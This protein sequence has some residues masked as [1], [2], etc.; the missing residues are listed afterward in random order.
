MSTTEVD[1]IGK[2]YS[3]DL[4]DRLGGVSRGQ[5]NSLDILPFKSY[6]SKALETSALSLGVQFSDN[7]LPIEQGPCN[8]RELV[9]VVTTG[10]C[11]T[12]ADPITKG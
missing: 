1:A 8:T 6:S 10:G 2:L 5:S 4:T 9:P 12:N 7:T 3:L 11:G